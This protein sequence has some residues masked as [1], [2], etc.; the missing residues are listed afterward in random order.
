MRT[1]LRQR[2]PRP[3]LENEA[4]LPWDGIERVEAD[5]TVVFTAETVKLLHAL[6]GATIESAHPRTAAEHARVILTALG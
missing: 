6:T 4:S 5:G 1:I 2:P 3:S